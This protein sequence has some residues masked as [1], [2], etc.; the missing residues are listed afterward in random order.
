MS[1][2]NFKITPKVKDRDWETKVLSSSRKHKTCAYCGSTI[3]PLDTNT[4]FTKRV[5]IGAETKYTTH[6]THGTKESPC[7]LGLARKL[8]IEL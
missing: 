1:I 2:F 4:S 8:N 7:S 3:I 6:Y 5:T